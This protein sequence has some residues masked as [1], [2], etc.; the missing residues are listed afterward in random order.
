MSENST[1]DTHEADLSMATNQCETETDN[2][3]TP[4]KPQLK[5]VEKSKN[6][7]TPELPQLKSKV[8]R[9]LQY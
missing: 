8:K 7:T 9:E 3:S 1:G 4:T 2:C 6:I 5:S